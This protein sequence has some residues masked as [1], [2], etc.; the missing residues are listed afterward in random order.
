[1][2]LYRNDSENIY[3]SS[4]KI[5]QHFREEPSMFTKIASYLKPS[6]SS[7]STNIYFPQT[8]LALI[9]KGQTFYFVVDISSTLHGRRDQKEP[10]MN[11]Q[12]AHL[13][14]ALFLTFFFLFGFYNVK[15]TGQQYLGDF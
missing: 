2:F 9:Y 5:N 3:I 13:D 12:T 14:F 1:M 10:E 7:K 4:S 8:N 15:A 11:S 6:K